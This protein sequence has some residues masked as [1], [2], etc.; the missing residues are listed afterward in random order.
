MVKLDIEGEEKHVLPH[1]FMT[2]ALCRVDEVYVELHTN[3]ARCVFEMIRRSPLLRR[4]GRCAPRLTLLD[5][6]SR[7]EGQRGAVVKGTRPRE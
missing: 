5:D 3:F 2:G 7:E 4:K 1:L 6:E